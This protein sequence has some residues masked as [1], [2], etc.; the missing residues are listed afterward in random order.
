MK[1]PLTKLEYTEKLVRLHLR[2]IALVNEEVSDSAIRRFIVQAGEDMEDLIKLCR[3][4]ITSKNPEKVNRYLENY[5]LVMDKVREVEEKDELR[6]FQSPVRGDE[7]MQI[8]NLRPG[9]K[10]GEI[11]SAIEDA[12]LDGIIPNNYDAAYEY[13]MKIK[14]AILDT[15]MGS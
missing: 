11:K 2:P 15:S 6:A 3:A 1:L 10:V 9:R 13:L 12:I 4:D 8:C 5:D 7:I 14:N